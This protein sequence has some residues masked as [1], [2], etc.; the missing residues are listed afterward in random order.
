MP[1][2][3]HLSAGREVQSLFG[4]CPH[5]FKR[6]FLLKS[7]LWQRKRLQVRTSNQHAVKPNTWCLLQPHA[8]VLSTGAPSGSDTPVRLTQVPGGRGGNFPVWGDA[9]SPESSDSPATEPFRGSLPKVCW[10]HLTIDACY[11]NSANTQRTLKTHSVHPFQL[12]E[13]QI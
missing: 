12:L 3:A 4:Q 8:P 13:Y 7:I 9:Q 11:L 1:H 6:G 5:E 10:P 2:S